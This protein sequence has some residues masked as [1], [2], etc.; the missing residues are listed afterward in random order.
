MSTIRTTLAICI[1]TLLGAL[2]CDPGETGEPLPD[3][4]DVALEA[5]VDS[6]DA[7]GRLPLQR[8]VLEALVRQDAA[9]AMD[10]VECPHHGLLAGFWGDDNHGG[11]IEGWYL[12][13]HGPAEGSLDG[14][15]SPLEC[16]ACPEGGFQGDWQSDQGETGGFG[17]RYDDGRFHGRYY[18]NV[19]QEDGQV[20]RE[21][22]GE[23]AGVYHRL[24]EEGG[25]F[26]G[27]WSHCGV[28]PGPHTYPDD[29]D[30]NADR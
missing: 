29:P 26:I 15:Y 5:A 30:T 11:A 14:R 16:D 22:L 18:E 7:D 6:L 20:R 9:E 8:D 23:M 19:V 4:V 25:Y 28:G 24:S 12:E 27:V 1:V 2:G 13:L 3:E 17:G 10:D 21:H